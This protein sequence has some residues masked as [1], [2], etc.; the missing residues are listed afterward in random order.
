[1]VWPPVATRDHSS[2][3]FLSKMKMEQRS[4]CRIS[5]AESTTTPNKE[6]KSLRS[7]IWR[8]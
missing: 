4:A 1:M 2:F 7:D 8:V 3:F 6:S 5:R